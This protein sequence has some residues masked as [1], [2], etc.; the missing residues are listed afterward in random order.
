MEYT[1]WSSSLKA[2]WWMDLKLFGVRVHKSDWGPIHNKDCC[3]VQGLNYRRLL[4]KQG[5]ALQLHILPPSP[6]PSNSTGISGQNQLRRHPSSEM[7]LQKARTQLTLK[8]TLQSCPAFKGRNLS[9]NCTCVCICAF[10]NSDNGFNA[11]NV[12]KGVSLILYLL[13][14]RREREVRLENVQWLLTGRVLPW[15][16]VH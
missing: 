11:I 14:K 5:T 15:W 16:H 9:L 2:I 8:Q 10:L 7:S 6:L 13:V 12:N 1:I 3:Q 4:A